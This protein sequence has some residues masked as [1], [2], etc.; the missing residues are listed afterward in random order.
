MVAAATLEST[1]LN[2]SSWEAK[3]RGFVDFPAVTSHLA[4]EL[5]KEAAKLGCN[6]LEIYYICGLFFFF[7]FICQPKDLF[8]NFICILLMIGADHGVRCR[9]HRWTASYLS[10]V[11]TVGR[12][13]AHLHLFTICKY[14][15][16]EIS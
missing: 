2:A 8:L 1:W 10:G 5:R 6:N 11:V 12:A 13:G 14:T 4:G 7:F 9:L 15:A 3:Q 16:T